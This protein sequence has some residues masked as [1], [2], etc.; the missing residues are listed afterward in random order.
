[1]A[2]IICGRH[3]HPPTTAATSVRCGRRRPG[4]I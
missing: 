2:A 3:P 1:M 4:P